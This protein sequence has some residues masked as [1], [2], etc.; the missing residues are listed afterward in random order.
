MGMD[1][2]KKQ[3]VIDDLHARFEKAQ[4]AV[5]TDFKG[6]DVASVTKFRQNCR[7]LAIDYFVTKNTLARRAVE[8][9]SFEDLKDHLAGVT[10]VGL[11][12]DDP[13]ALAKAVVDFAKEDEN[14]KVKLG[15]LTRNQ[16]VLTADEVRVLA[17]VPSRE[18][19]LTKLAFL[20][21]SQHT[22]FVRVLNEVMGK[23]VR[24]VDQVRVKKEQSN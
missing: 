22:N 3:E 18:E 8:G 10:S 11:T 20:L 5:V 15:F 21:K 7:G 23:F 17:S 6:M 19:L 13:V 9:T 2:A 4:A 14:L 24:A 1:R 16:Q 12:Y